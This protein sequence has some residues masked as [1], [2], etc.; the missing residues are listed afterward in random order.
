MNKLPPFA[1]VVLRIGIS[2][3]FLWFGMNQIIDPTSWIGFIPDSVV[4]MT[5]LTTQTLVYLNALFE[6]I[7]GSFLLF[8]FYTR[9]VALLL[10]LHIADITYIVGLDSI[11]IRDLGITIA[12]LAIFLNGRDWFSLDRFT[13]DTIPE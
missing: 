10:A 13:T 11:G 3:V 12:T 8:G 9:T 4:N 2:G 6:I 1:P 7:L 5:G